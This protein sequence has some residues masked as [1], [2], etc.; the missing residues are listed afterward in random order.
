MG[1]E[2]SGL[3]SPFVIF[4]EQHAAFAG[5]ECFYRM[6][7]KG[8]DV[9]PRM[10]SEFPFLPVGLETPAYAVA[11]IF[12]HEGSA[13]P[14]DSS[15]LGHV[16]G[17]PGIVHGNDGF[18][19]GFPAGL[20]SGGVDVGCGWIDVAKV[21]NGSDIGGGVRGSDKS[22]GRSDNPV[23]GADPEHPH[24]KV[25]GGGGVANGDRMLGSDKRGKFLLEGF[26]LWTTCQEIRAK[27][28]DDGRDVVFGN[29]LSA[30]GNHGK[31]REENAE[32]LKS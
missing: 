20:Q 31:R 19:I 22:D 30:V 1:A 24:G 16:A 13:T 8:G 15:N 3:R 29:G 5:G 4:G 26:D 21:G 2:E 10:A 18:G 12:D 23:S 28:T 11:G 7:G 25:Q 17:L 27:R 9:G 6:E 32:T 14:R